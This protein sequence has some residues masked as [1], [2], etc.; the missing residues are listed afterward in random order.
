M[1]TP[2]TVFTVPRQLQ[3]R[4]PGRPRRRR[5]RHRA[6]DPHRHP[7][8]VQQHRHDHAG[9]RIGDATLVRVPA[10]VRPRQPT[11]IGL[12]GESAGILRSRRDWSEHD[13]RR[14][15]PF[16]QGVSVT[17]LQM[18]CDLPDHRQRRRPGRADAGRRA[19]AGPTARVS[20]RAAPATTRV[21]SAETAP[22]VRDDARERRRPT[23]AP[24]RWPQIA[25]LPG[26]RQDRY[27]AA[28]RPDLRLLPRLHVLVRRVRAGRRPAVRRRRRRCRTPSAARTAAS[29]AG[30]VFKQVM[31]FALQQLRIAPTGTPRPHLGQVLVTAGTTAT[32][33]CPT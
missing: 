21:V 6:T 2:D 20:R 16:G 27:R 22:T 4:R 8:P 19:I 29:L 24:R 1:A 12:P 17:A 18:A 9:A 10:D 25:G 14:T 30:P 5:A 32:A 13:A 7:R 3:A 26:R 28:G 31:R 11:G 15:V 23:R 33:R